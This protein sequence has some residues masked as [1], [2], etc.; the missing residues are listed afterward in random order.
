M[1][2]STAMFERHLDL[3]GRRFRFT[4]LDEIGAHL[5]RASRSPNAWPR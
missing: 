5:A 1:L 4:T 3:V 2:T